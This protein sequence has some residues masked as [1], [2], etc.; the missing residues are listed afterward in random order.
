MAFE[1]STSISDIVTL[2]PPAKHVLSEYG[3]HC[4][5]CAGS[6]YETLEQGCYGHGFSDE[7]IEALVEDLNDALKEMPARPQTITLT[8]PAAKAIGDIADSE[9]KTGEGLVVTVDGTGGFCMEFRAEPEGD[10]KIFFHPDAPEIRL[11]AS[12]MTL[13]R[14]GGAT[15]D[16]RNERFKL[17]LPED[18]QATACACGGNCDC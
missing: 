13:Q 11:F 16:F 5:G 15:I 18:A 12:A 2:C 17:D 8:L 7:D 10:E 3:L 1:R 6:T 4:T 14:I 9:G